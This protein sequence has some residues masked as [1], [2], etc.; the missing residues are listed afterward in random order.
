MSWMVC[1]IDG[2]RFRAL[3]FPA[4]LYS[5]LFQTET[6]KGKSIGY[7]MRRREGGGGRKRWISRRVTSREN[8]DQV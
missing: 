8:H 4:I 5:G 1:C 7:R 6:P 3:M 2:A